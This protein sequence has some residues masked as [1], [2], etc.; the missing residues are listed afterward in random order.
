MVA[1]IDSLISFC[2][3]F[4][5]MLCSSLYLCCIFRLLV[6]SSI[7]FFM[8]LLIPSAYNITLPFAFL[9][10]RPMVWISEVSVLKKPSLSASKIATTETSGISS[11]SLKRF[12]PISTSYF[13]SLSSLIISILSIASMSECI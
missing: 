4:G 7:A 12:I 2:M 13:P 1:S 11:P 9:A 5:V 6:V 3:L 10:A 8:A